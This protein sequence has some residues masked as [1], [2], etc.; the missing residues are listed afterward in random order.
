MADEE[1]EAPGAS[2]E[3][4]GPPSTPFDHPFFLPVV[5]WLFA[6]WFAY[7]ILTGAQAYIDHPTFN[8]GGLVVTAL[9]AIWFTWRGVQERRA[10]RKD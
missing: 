8:R 4:E 9:L 6:G 2:E 5:A 3:D 10:M 7:D 1:R